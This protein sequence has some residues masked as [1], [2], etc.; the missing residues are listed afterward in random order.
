[1]ATN[2]AE[3]RRGLIGQT[4]V[5]QM[6]LEIAL[7]ADVRNC[8]AEIVRLHNHG[9]DMVKPGWVDALF[10]AREERARKYAKELRVCREFESRVLPDLLKIYLSGTAE[11]RQ[12]IRDLLR[13]C[14]QVRW[15]LGASQPT[16]GPASSSAADLRNRLALFSMKDGDMT[17][18][19]D[20][21]LTLDAICT[22][23]REANLDVAH[24]LREAA[25][26]SSD[27]PRGDRPSF[28]ATLLKR[29][30]TPSP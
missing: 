23:A 3:P 26:L 6:P 10:A 14:R 29:A 15:F 19:R 24:L 8:E 13:E 7:V 28:R 17:D 4:Q 1:M 16:K 25:D 22:D 20:E 11:D 12:D 9:V 30:D 5:E 27:S 18:W 21:L 2:E